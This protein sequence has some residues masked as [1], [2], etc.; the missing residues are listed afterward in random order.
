M[1][2]P[3]PTRRPRSTKVRAPRA[4]WREN[5]TGTQDIGNPI[6]ATD[7]DGGTLTYRLE[8]TDRASFTLDVN[9]L[10]TRSSETYDY[11]EK[12]SYV[13]IVRVED[14]QGGSNTIEVTINLIDQQEPPE[15]P[16][17]PSVSAASS[18][19]LTVTWDEPTNTGPD[20]DDY[21]VQYR[22]GGGGGFTPWTHNS[23]ERTATITGRSPGTSY[24]VQ[25][26]ARNA[27]G[28]SDWSAVGYG[29]HQC[30]WATDIRRRVERHP[31]LRREH[32]RAC[33]TSMIR[34]A[35]PTRRTPP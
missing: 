29:K 26:R 13:V 14:G 17:A 31:R 3:L 33:R 30:Q 12:P 35:Q 19:S 16:A 6:T 27:E 2:G 1:D 9:Q 10:Q 32:Q 15:T 34:S 22:E 8:G 4:G 11:E 20:I 24:E 7:S 23:A 21:D 18:T 28:T 5:T 25:V